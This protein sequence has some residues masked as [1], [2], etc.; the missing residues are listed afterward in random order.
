L[1]QR[2]ID[3]VTGFGGEKMETP[4]HLCRQAAELVA[5]RSVLFSTKDYLGSQGVSIHKVDDS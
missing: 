1:D 5:I 3:R 4:R 2:V